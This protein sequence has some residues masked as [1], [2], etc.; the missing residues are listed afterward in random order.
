M[1]VAQ[2][3]LVGALELL[4]WEGEQVNCREARLSRGT[5]ISPEIVHIPLLWRPCKQIGHTTTQEELWIMTFARAFPTSFIVPGGQEQVIGLLASTLIQV[6]GD[7]SWSIACRIK[8][9]AYA[10]YAINI[11]PCLKRGQGGD[12]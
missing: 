11:F 3:F 8:D 4:W 9:Q 10:C 1:E 2:A 7:D 5:A 12:K 6:G